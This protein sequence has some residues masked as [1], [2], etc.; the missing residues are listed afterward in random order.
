MQNKRS[1][2]LNLARTTARSLTGVVMSVS[3]VP[4]DFSRANR[5]MVMTGA[6]KSRINQRNSERR[7]N[8]VIGA[9]VGTSWRLASRMTKLMPMSKTAP[10]MTT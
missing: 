2:A 7:N 5:R 10:A 8:S 6:E 3:K 1:A 9:R 4:E